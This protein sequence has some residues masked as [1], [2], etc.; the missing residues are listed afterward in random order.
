MAGVNP[1]S[2]LQCPLKQSIIYGVEPEGISDRFRRSNPHCLNLPRVLHVHI[3]LSPKESW[4]QMFKWLVSTRSG[5]TVVLQNL[6]P[7]R[8]HDCGRAREWWMK[9]DVV[10]LPLHSRSLTLFLPC[11]TAGQP[12]YT[13][14]GLS[15]H[16]LPCI[17]KW[18]WININELKW[19]VA[20]RSSK[21]LCT[22]WRTELLSYYLEGR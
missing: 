4:K 7:T 2:D 8:Q 5:R 18:I 9:S 6:K 12:P 21:Q 19:V 20:H 1:G 3:C 22:C 11:H 14:S 15:S 16:L 10:L 17:Q 13:L